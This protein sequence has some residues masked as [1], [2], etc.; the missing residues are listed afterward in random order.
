MRETF[1]LPHVPLDLPIQ[2]GE[3]LVGRPLSEDL[4]FEKIRN[5]F[6]ALGQN[7]PLVVYDVDDIMHLLEHRI[8]DDLGIDAKRCLATYSIREN[9]LM[10]TEEQDAFIAA[11]SNSKYF[12]EIEFLPGVERILEPCRFGAE[13]QIV[14]NAFSEDISRLKS[15]QLLAAVPGL[16]PEQIVMNVIG[17]GG[18]HK[19]ELSQHTTIL[20]DDSPFNV[21]KSPALINV[22][23]TWMPWSHS[24]EAIKQLSNKPVT[25][26]KDLNTMIDFTCKAVQSMVK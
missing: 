1:E 22:M 11:F 23:P 9:T 21:E 14:S 19:K 25:W 20:H 13:V 8:L 10:T 12:H 6:Q 4:F 2:D 15:E 7:R 18:A 5:E 16:R 17:Y 24:K 3:V 26:R